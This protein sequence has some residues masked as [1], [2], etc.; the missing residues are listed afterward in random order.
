MT[1][2][3]P[4]TLMAIVSQELR[5][6]KVTMPATLAERW[7]EI[8]DTYVVDGLT[9]SR[10]EFR[11]AATDAL[12]AGRDLST[13]DALL[14]LATRYTLAKQI[15]IG[16]IVREHA[17]TLRRQT[18][19]EHVDEICSELQAVF[20]KASAAIAKARVKI[21]DGL[22]LTNLDGLAGVPAAQMTVWGEAFEAV[23]RID[24]VVQVWN[25]LGTFTGR[26]YIQ[27]LMRPLIIADLDLDQLDAISDRTVMIAPVHSGYD[28]TLATFE[29]FSERVAR[30]QQ[31]AGRRD[32]AV[33]EEFKQI[34]S[35][36]AVRVR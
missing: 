18:I 21:G 12:E 25:L 26:T 1:Y 5:N 13:D 23:D 6:L 31:Q 19:C 16:E 3:R 8:T 27:D 22:D 32:R 34:A 9:P 14:T 24:H 10:D 36:T 15:G 2:T 33:A 20:N 17:D 35:R 4:I 11:N 28:L 7:Q 30:V 29:E